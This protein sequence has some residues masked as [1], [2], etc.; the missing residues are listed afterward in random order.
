[1]FQ[2]R[3]DNWSKVEFLFTK[4]LGIS[5]LELDQ[6]AFYRVEELMAN[7]EEFVN[8]EEKQ[9]KAQQKEQEKQQ[10][11]HQP[12]DYRGFKIPKIEIPKIN[13]PNITK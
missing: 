6:L 8:E 9:Y 10:K 1:L 5:P 7:Y 13:I 12:T 3:L 2:I 11:M 4:N